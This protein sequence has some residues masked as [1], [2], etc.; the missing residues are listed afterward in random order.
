MLC[1]VHGHPQ[2]R[3]PQAQDTWARWGHHRGGQDLASAGLRVEHHRVGRRCSRRHGTKGADPPSTISFN[4]PGH[5]P[6][7]KSLQSGRG[8][9]GRANQCQRP[10]QDRANRCQRLARTIQIVASLNPK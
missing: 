9:Q 5:A 4:W 8:C 3:L 10:Y 6:L 7:I 1:Q 2:L